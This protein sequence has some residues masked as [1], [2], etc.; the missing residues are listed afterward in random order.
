MYIIRTFALLSITLLSVGAWS[1][2]LPLQG[3]DAND[4]KSL[5][6]ETSANFNHTSVSGASS[7]GTLFGFEIGVVGGVAKT[8]K[9]D[10]LVE[11]QGGNADQIPHG[12]ILGVLTVPAGITVEGGFIPK[13]GKEEFKFNTL[14]L[15]VKWTPTEVFLDWP[16]AIA[17]KFHFTKTSLDFKDTISGIPTTF[18]YDSTTTAFTMLVSKNFVMV[19]PYFGVQF[20]Q[21]KGDLDV[22][23]STTVF[24]TG[25]ASGSAKSTATGFLLGTEL[26][27]LVF[28]A[29]VEYAKIFDTSRFTGK[30][31]FYF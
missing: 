8:P 10:K 22:T 26:K 5:V 28:K 6:K 9:I 2:N 30:I 21:T 3:L 25:G 12:E 31:S 4:M 23:G 7:L 13:V 24:D 14:S 11:P 17:G 27:L 16:V 1:Q 29:G 18:G 15:G 19:E 20:A